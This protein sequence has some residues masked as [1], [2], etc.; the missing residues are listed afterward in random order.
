MKISIKESLVFG[1]HTFKARPGFFIQLSLLVLAAS[2]LSSFMQGFLTSLLGKS[3]GDVLSVAVALFTDT[4]IGMGMLTVY[5]KAHDAVMTPTLKDAWNPRPF[6]KYVFTSALLT[7]ML[8]VG[9]V[10]LV[11]PGIILSIVFTFATMLV[12]D[13]EL[14][15]FDA[16][17][18]S[19]R[20]TKGHRWKLFGLMLALIGVNILGV[21]ALVI[22]LFVSIPVTMFAMI[23]V[24]RALSAA[25]AISEVVSA[26]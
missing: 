20:L 7:V 15:P 11:V 24:Y 25:P 26:S 17:K 4:L 1:W 5:L 22:G 19:A 13:R 9:Y 18:E 10:L 2:V 23:H 3:I 6:W 16:F 21:L 14:G 12:I 8:C